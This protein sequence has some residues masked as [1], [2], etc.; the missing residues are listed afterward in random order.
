MASPDLYQA[1]TLVLE[2]ATGDAPLIHH[3]YRIMFEGLCLLFGLLT[4]EIS[5][6]WFVITSLIWASIA[7]LYNLYHL[8]TAVIYEPSNISEIFI[9]ILVSVASLFLVKNLNKWRKENA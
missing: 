3:I 2:D 4:I 9:L 8:V 5:K 6:K 1:E 7:G